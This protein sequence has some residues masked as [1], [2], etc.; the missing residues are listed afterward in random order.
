MLIV[1]SNLTILLRLMKSKE[2][3]RKSARKVKLSEPGE[4]I[5]TEENM[6]RVISL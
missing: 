3:V 1:S 2:K 5:N 4:V 6:N